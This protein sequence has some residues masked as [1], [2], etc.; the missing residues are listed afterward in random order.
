MVLKETRLA[1]TF[2][3]PRDD[4]RMDLLAQ[5]D[6]H[7]HCPFKGNASYW[8]VTVGD[9]NTENVVWSYEEP[10]AEAVDV[11]DYVAFDW[12]RMDAWFEDDAPILKREAE[13]AIT[14][15]PYVD[16]LLLDAWQ[17]ETSADLVDAFVAQ[18]VDQG[19]P[20]IRLVCSYAHFIHKCSRPGIL[21][22]AKHKGWKRRKLL[23][24]FCSD[25][26]ISKAHTRRF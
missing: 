7:T 8:S 14:D 4:V 16:W 1:P 3:F 11:K 13:G 19:L 9:R 18:L 15:N 12:D 20:I 17:C 22:G 25:P 21:G 23:T 5:T 6:N 2:Y 26:N 24:M 10:Y